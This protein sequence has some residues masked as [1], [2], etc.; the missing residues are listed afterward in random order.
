MLTIELYTQMGTH[1]GGFKETSNT[2]TLVE[3]ATVTGVGY[4]RAKRLAAIITHLHE[5]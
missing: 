4:K 1:V 3:T 5:E 2:W